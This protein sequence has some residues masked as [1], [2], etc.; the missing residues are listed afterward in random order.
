MTLTLEDIARLS[1]VSRSTVSRVING[2]EKVHKETRQRVLDM[3][4]QHNFQPNMA[5]RHLA[6][7]RTNVVGLVI[8]TGVGNIF[9]DLYFSRLIHGVS[10]E[11]NLREYSV[12]LWLAE[13]EFERRMIRQIINHG[14]VDGVVVS[15][16]LMD[17]PIVESLHHSHI[18]FVLIGHHPDLTVNLVDIDNI[19]AAFLAA[20][21]LISCNQPRTRV[22]TISGPQNTITGHDRYIGYHLALKKHG[23][24]LDNS[25]V[26]EGNFSEGSG[27][28]AMQKLLS[29]H[30]DAVFAA[31]DMM[32]AG[33]YRAIREADLNIPN[34]IA[35]VGFDDVSIAIQ[36]DPPL[37]TIRQPI[38]RMGA[39]AVETLI[40][41]I[42][43]AE[44]E[45]T[46]IIMQ[47]EL[48]VRNSCGCKQ[49]LETP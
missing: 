17:D 48:V 47:P 26:V 23:L 14:V 39:Q 18:P 8:P 49:L 45:A 40:N 4:Q 2:D 44:T 22:A 25:L 7:G 20:S 27:Y 13:P 1:G 33:A 30:P 31:S 9:N 32:A 28:T 24:A 5:A 10:A 34:D 15:S 12:M 36:L 37:T 3:V 42:Q 41:L 11:C 43:R 35:L 29:A 6:A 38:Q 46:Q 21:H 19:Q 16:T